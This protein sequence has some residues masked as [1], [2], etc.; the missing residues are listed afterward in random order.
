MSDGAIGIVIPVFNTTGKFLDEC[1]TSAMAQTIPASVVVVDDGS[2]N[3]DTLRSLD[4]WERRGIRVLRHESN[5]GVSTAL[6]TGI[7]AQATEFI[8]PVGSDDRLRPTY[9][10]RVRDALAND[11]TVGIV[12]VNLNQFGAR[13][14]VSP[15]AREVKAED[16]LFANVISGASA[17]RRSDWLELGGFSSTTNF[18][19]DWDFWLRVLRSGRRA[20]GLDEAL[21]EYR[22]HPAQSIATTVGEARLA[23][24]LNVVGRNRALWE[25]NVVTVM[26]AYWRLKDHTD[27]QE[28]RLSVLERRYGRLNRALARLADATVRL[29]KRQR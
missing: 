27:A 20:I 29:R 17:F 13:E 5:H 23:Q 19:E 11:P 10:V 8:A 21:Y 12:S 22:Q 14:L 4:A 6:N 25:E 7:E 26:E 9:C 15:S 16:L 2:V 3:P 24:Q 1:V 18:G 28:A